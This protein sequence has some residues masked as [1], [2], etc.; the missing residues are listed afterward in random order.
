MI[1]PIVGDA[2]RN[3]GGAETKWSNI[4]EDFSGIFVSLCYIPALLTSRI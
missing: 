1:V 4:F 2:R 3:Y